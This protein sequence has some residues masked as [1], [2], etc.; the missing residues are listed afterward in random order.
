MLF[1]DFSS[2]HHGECKIDHIHAKVTVGGVLEY[3]YLSM[4]LER[5]RKCKNWD[6]WRET[7]T[8]H[9]LS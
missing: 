5:P 4:L 8:V 3:K 2:S 1:L 6:V 7:E 9:L